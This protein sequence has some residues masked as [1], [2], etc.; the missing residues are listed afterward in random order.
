MF[1]IVPRMKTKSLKRLWFLTM[2]FAFAVSLWCAFSIPSA[3]NHLVDTHFA[4]PSQV[5][6]PSSPIQLPYDLENKEEQ[7]TTE[8]ED[9]NPDGFCGPH[10]AYISGE[11]V[12]NT[13]SQQ[14]Q[15]VYCVPVI[16]DQTPRY[17]RYRTLII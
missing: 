7:I 12:F 6:S 17:I 3:N 10:L 1:R 9:S 8:D 4:E 13:F 14:T 5:I 2:S 16:H 15:K 11:F